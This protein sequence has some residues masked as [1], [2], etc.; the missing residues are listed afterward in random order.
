MGKNKMKEVGLNKMI[1]IL[2][3]EDEAINGKL[4]Q[5]YI[6]KYDIDERNID[7]ATNGFEA[8]GMMLIKEYNLVFLDVKMPKCNG[9]DVLDIIRQYKDKFPSFGQL[10][11]CMTTSLGGEKDKKLYNLKGANSYIIKPFDK[12]IVLNIFDKIFALEKNNDVEPEEDNDFFDFDEEFDD[13]YD[14]D[15]DDIQDVTDANIT[16]KKIPA[17]QFLEDYEDLSYILEDIDEID[18]SL[19]NLIESLDI[20]T[21]EMLKDDIQNILSVY[22]A[23]VKSFSDFNELSNAIYTISTIIDKL[24]LTAFNSQSQTYIVEFIRA[25]LSDLSNWK[26]H[27]FVKQDA[28]DVFYINASV[29]NSYV[30]LKGII[31]GNN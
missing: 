9:I 20:D 13:F 16:H 18:E 30:Q 17:S 7:I 22:A 29:I 2:I 14:F 25:I 11:I 27:V 23:F 10:H 12:D 21:L 1:K 8:L 31:D 3:V 15:D 19:T 4:L 26:E 24:N 28:I 5:R 6:T